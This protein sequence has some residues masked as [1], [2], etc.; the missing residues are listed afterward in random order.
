MKRLINDNTV[1]KGELD[2]DAVQIA[3]LQYRN[4]PDPDKKQCVSSAA[5][6]A[7]IPGKYRPHEPWRETLRA[8][9]EALRKRHVR[10]AETWAEHTKHLPPLAIVASKVLVFSALLFCI[11]NNRRKFDNNSET[12]N[13]VRVHLFS[14][15][16]SFVFSDDVFASQFSV[17]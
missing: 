3:I 7:I 9:E 12:Q 10:T 2:T 15:A 8:R 14:A 5:R 1:P 4:T 13:V 17:G 6:H 11:H 16:T